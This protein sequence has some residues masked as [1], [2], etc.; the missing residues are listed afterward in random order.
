MQEIE[1]LQFFKRR[2]LI[3]K[4]WYHLRMFSVILS[5]NIQTPAN[6][7]WGPGVNIIWKIKN[8]SGAPN[9]SVKLFRHSFLDFIYYFQFLQNHMAVTSV[10]LK[11]ELLQYIATYCNGSIFNETDFKMNQSILQYQYRYFFY[12]RFYF[13]TVNWKH[14]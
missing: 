13:F 7:F 9:I 2:I 12:N 5:Y 10:S 4:Q 14:L 6:I 1:I 11:I 3:S 8:Y